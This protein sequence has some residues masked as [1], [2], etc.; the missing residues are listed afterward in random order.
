MALWEHPFD[1][2]YSGEV[3]D[4]H[5]AARREVIA[6]LVELAREHAAGHFELYEAAVE[7][8]REDMAQRAHSNH[9]A[10]MEVSRVL[11]MDPRRMTIPGGS[12]PP[13]PDGSPWA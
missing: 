3:A 5:A 7:H 6:E 9:G 11:R 12:S 1:C 8:G 2:A 4:E 13:P 10:W